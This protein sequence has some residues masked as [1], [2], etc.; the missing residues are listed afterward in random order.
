MVLGL[1]RH[2]VFSLF[3]V[4]GLWSLV[5]G[6]WSLVFG[7]WYIWGTT[8]L[9][10]RVALEAVPPALMGAFAGSIAGTLLVVYVRLR[11]QALP[12]VG[13]GAAWRSRGC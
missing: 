8:Y 13:A 2:H 10:I 12:H 11:G 4:F 7:L 1:G 5:F 6:L 3:L 9:G